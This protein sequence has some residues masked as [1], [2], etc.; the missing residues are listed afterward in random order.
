MANTEKAMATPKI[1]PIQGKVLDWFQLVIV[2]NNGIKTLYKMW[3]KSTTNTFEGTQLSAE[4]V[5]HHPL[6]MNI[7]TVNIDFM[8]QNML[9]NAHSILIVRRH[10]CFR[11]I[12][13][14]FGL[15]GISYVVQV[16][17]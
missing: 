7:E 10:F 12:N 6:S 13:A 4:V 17:K 3:V 9:K 5:L 11:W 14:L 8:L 15:G 1:P 16:S 2:S